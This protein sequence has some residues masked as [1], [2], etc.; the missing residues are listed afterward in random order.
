[1]MNAFSLQLLGMFVDLVFIVVGRGR[2]SLRLLPLTA[3]ES[4]DVK[5][6]TMKVAD[7]E[8]MTLI[9]TSSSIRPALWVHVYVLPGM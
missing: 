2:V 4:G 1:M 9:V 7:T 8:G 3:L 6:T 5:S